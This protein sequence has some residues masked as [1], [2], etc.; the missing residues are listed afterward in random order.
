M[1]VISWDKAHKICKQTLSKQH[2]E[3]MILNCKRLLLIKLN[4]PAAA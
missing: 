1:L 4:V 2:I 3:V